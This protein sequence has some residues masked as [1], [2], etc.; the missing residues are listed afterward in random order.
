MTLVLPD[1]VPRACAASKSTAVPPSITPGLNVR[2]SSP[3]SFSRKALRIRAA[4]KI[5]PGPNSCRKI[6]DECAG[7]PVDA[8]LP[9]R[10]AAPRGDGVRRIAGAILEADRD[11]GA[12]RRRDERFA[13]LRQRTAGVFFVAGHHDG[14]VHVL[15]HAGGLERLRAPAG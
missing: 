12:L 10:R 13:R 3:A 6:C 4:S 5:A 11:L 8:Q 14:D 15:Q 7:V 1:A 9:V 2:C